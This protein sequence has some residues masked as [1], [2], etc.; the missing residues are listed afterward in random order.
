VTNSASQLTSALP[1]RIGIARVRACGSSAFHSLESGSCGEYRERYGT[2][3][4][5][6]DPIRAYVSANGVHRGAP[7]RGGKP[8][9]RN[10]RAYLALHASSSVAFFLALAYL[11]L[12]S[13]RVSVYRGRAGSSRSGRTLTITRDDPERRK[14][15]RNDLYPS[16]RRFEASSRKVQ[17]IRA[18]TMQSRVNGR[19]ANARHKTIV[20]DSSQ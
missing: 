6:L 17:N 12:A 16:L 1:L 15:E 2:D 5:H 19:G 18:N 9:W 14:Q 4:R 13:R 11:P 10:L 20:R 3:G 8:V 7:I